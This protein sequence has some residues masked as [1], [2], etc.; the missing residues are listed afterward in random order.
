MKIRRYVEYMHEEEIYGSQ[1]G[2]YIANDLSKN[3]REQLFEDAYL[4]LLTQFPIFK[5]FGANFIKKLA[6]N[7]EE[8]TLPPEEILFEVNLKTYLFL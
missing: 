1:R 3:L 4:S 7:V 6:Q 5:K 8:I 2:E